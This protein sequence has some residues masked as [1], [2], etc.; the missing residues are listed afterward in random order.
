VLAD[1]RRPP[2]EAAGALH[3]LPAH[4]RWKHE[5]S[6]RWWR[7]LGTPPQ[8]WGHLRGGGVGRD[9]WAPEDEWRE[10]RR[11]LS[12]SLPIGAVSEGGWRLLLGVGG[13]G[14]P[15]WAH[16]ALRRVQRSE[17]SEEEEE[18]GLE[19]RYAAHAAGAYGLAEEEVGGRGSPPPP[20][21]EPTRGGLWVREAAPPPTLPSSLHVTTPHG[22][23]ALDA[24]S[25][26]GAGAAWGAAGV[27]LPWVQR[28]SGARA[29]L[30]PP[31]ARLPGGWCAV[32]GGSGA[33][34]EDPILRFVNDATG[35]SQNAPPAEAL[36]GALPP[37]LAPA[38]SPPP[39]AGSDQ[40]WVRVR[41]PSGLRVW[42]ETVSALALP[43]NEGP[44]V[45]ARLRGGW[46]VVGEGRAQRAFFHAAKNIV[47]AWD[48]VPEEADEE[49]ATSGDGW[50]GES[51]L[52]G[53][54]PPLPPP[55]PPPPDE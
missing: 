14:E 4:S 3:W 15:F 11:V 19:A 17:P 5:H 53:N 7:Q 13:A 24:T 35:A 18:E 22:A 50:R 23:W 34:G 25:G 54:A 48:R 39:S 49:W 29:A 21:P 33:P 52:E 26:E 9:M 36:V 28:E 1:G 47:R 37:R 55:L 10:E 31:N 30:P 46:E 32:Y 6:G 16:P 40:L 43:P 45:G 27:A 51:P 42:M 44:P 20:P 2:R 8:A 41:Q 38:P 12:G